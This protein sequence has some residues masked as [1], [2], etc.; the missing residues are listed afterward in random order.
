MRHF[1][2]SHH[3]TYPETFDFFTQYMGY[4]LGKYMHVRQ[5]III[6]IEDVINLHFGN[7]QCMPEDYR[8]NV[9]KSKATI[10][11]SYFV[12]RDLTGYNF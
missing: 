7:H 12:A 2:S 10:I 8:A 5:V 1:Q 4:P 9:Q 6:H 3:H 11:L